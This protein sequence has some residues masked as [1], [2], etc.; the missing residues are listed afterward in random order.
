MWSPLLAALA[1]TGDARPATTDAV[2]Q[3]LVAAILLGVLVLLTLEM[4]HRVLVMAGAVAL[5]WGITY[6]TPWHLSGF[7]ASQQAID[8]NVLLLLAGMMAIVG[9]LKTTGVFPH[10][11][12]RILGW[13]GGRPRLIQRIVL[14]A[15]A[16]LS[17]FLDNVTT[18][19]FMTP[20]VTEAARRTMV[21][22]AAFLLPM[23]MAANIGGTAT[24]IGDPPN[25]MIGSGA[26]LGF[27]EFLWHLAVPVAVMLL[28]LDGYA[29]RA[30]RRDLDQP[31]QPVAPHPPPVCDA[32]LLR[33][34]LGI[35]AVVF[36]GFLTHGMTG[37]PVA[38]P[39][40]I[41]AAAL[42]IVQD[43]RYLRYVRPSPAERAHGML[44]V[45]ERE[46][47][48]PTLSFFALLFILVGAAVQTGLIDTLATGIIGLVELM[49]AGLGLGEA[50]TL[51]AAALL[52]CWAS[53]VL[54]AFIDNIPYVAVAIPLV[55]RLGDGLPGD[56]T[57][58]WWALAMGACLGGNG[59]AI[60]AS[61]NVTTLGLAERE[62]VRISFRE[63]A[64]FGVPVT[65]MTLVI[66]SVFLSGYVL[67]GEP[68]TLAAG[69]GAVAIVLAG[70]MVRSRPA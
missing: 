69:L 35:L 67:V 51:L 40:M 59:T 64:R 49:R 9:V 53:G 42:L 3:L 1:L 27:L 58:L 62:G 57:V 39:A 12:A 17:A 48:W 37:M 33:W 6:L 15:T 55:A 13:S 65:A 24:L 44:E 43:V 50:G 63:F 2:S 52:I 18:V 30:C 32:G 10:L 23:V 14:G 4:A 56:T 8:L 7:A 19:I 41:G 47:E 68:L 66:A 45:L 26:G 28:A 36:V 16:A 38:V 61:A 20:M 46:I 54:S 34:A 60:A 11:V 5:V 31:A 25:V 22:A 29:R 70:R 21:P